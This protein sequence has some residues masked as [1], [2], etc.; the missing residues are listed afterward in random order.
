[1][2]TQELNKD[3]PVGDS[4]ECSTNYPTPKH[5]LVSRIAFLTG[6]PKAIFDNGQFQLELYEELQKCEPA[7]IV[8]NLCMVRTAVEQ[9]Y[10]KIQD[11]ILRN[12]KSFFNLPDLIPMES[13]KMIMDNNILHIRNKDPLDQIIIEL[14][15]RI[16]DRINNCM[17][18]FPSW[19]RLDYIK[20]L[21]IIPNGLK[22]DGILKAAREYY[23]NINR[24]PYQVFL[25][26]TYPTEGN[27]Y[28]NDEKF[29]TLLYE[30]NGDFFTDF[31]RV[32]DVSEHT[33]TDI[34]SFFETS[35][36]ACVL[37]DC[38]NADPYRVCTVLKYLE[39]HE[40]GER[41]YNILLIDD[42][43]TTSAWST[44]NQFTSF[45]VVHWK[46]QRV[47]ASK[48]IVDPSLI[49]KC[50]MLHYTKNV[51]SFILFASDSDYWGMID[52]FYEEIPQ[53]D[54]TFLLMLDHGRVSPL[55]IEKYDE[56]NI[57]YCFPDTFCSNSSTDF[58]YGFLM[59]EFKEE[60]SDL[61]DI[62][63]PALF[64]SIC[65]KN[66][67]DLSTTEQQQIF[68]RFIKPTQIV[69]GKDGKLQIA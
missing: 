20:N 38:E 43:N 41:I 5:E 17:N 34:H 57:P 13:L 30:A 27:L 60:L 18:I 61:L 64:N 25:N 35:R 48:S 16:T 54:L 47:L 49:T 33:E 2:N 36:K 15:R 56:Y 8:R 39:E 21:F 58:Q 6:V 10:K 22:P 53:E 40:L 28:Y 67:V 65:V 11:A 37:V 7:V 46:R 42:P 63:L 51:D 32:R 52:T 9:K 68:S 66:R 14:N 62:D 55:L 59:K 45:P 31:S 44:L 12:H 4:V 23:S 24:Y 26:W 1:M 29:V 69:I 50:C 3:M 19:I